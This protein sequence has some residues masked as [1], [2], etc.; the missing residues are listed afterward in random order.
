VGEVKKGDGS[1]E[2]PRGN[3]VWV[4]EKAQMVSLITMGFLVFEGEEWKM[5]DDGG[6][7][8]MGA[9]PGRTSRHA[10]LLLLL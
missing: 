9:A 6:A 5:I 7:R 4:G 10:A 8:E 1:K 3:E 2:T